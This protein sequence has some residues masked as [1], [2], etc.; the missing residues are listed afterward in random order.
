ME[1]NHRRICHSVAPK[2]AQDVQENGKDSDSS[3][4]AEKSVVLHIKEEKE[5]EMN[6]LYQKTVETG[7]A[8]K[9]TFPSS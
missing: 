7:R 3:G 5:L 8:L 2:E 6:L 9:I 1:L 4:M